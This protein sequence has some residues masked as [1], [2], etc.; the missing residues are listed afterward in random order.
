MN[1][2][3]VLFSLRDACATLNLGMRFEGIDWQIQRGQHWAVVGGNGS[4]KTALLALL[5]RRIPLSAGTLQ[6]A[7]AF[8]VERDIALVSMDEAQRLIDGDIRHDISDV[9]DNAVD[10]GTTLLQLLRQ[11]GIAEPAAREAL[12]ALGIGELAARGLRFVSTGQLRRALIARAMA[13]NYPLIAFDNPLDG[14]DAQSRDSIAASITQLMTPAQTTLYLSR[15]YSSLPAGITHVLQLRDCRV[16]YAGPRSQWQQATQQQARPAVATRAI[17]FAAPTLIHFDDVDIHYED[18]CIFRHANFS[19]HRF[20]HT[21][22][23]GPNGCGKSTLLA[24]ISGDNHKAY[25]KNISLFGRRR[26]SGESVWEIKA[27]IG[28]VSTALHSQYPRGFNGLQ[29]V[30]SGLFDTLGLYDNFGIREKNLALQ[31]LQ[32]CGLSALAD[33]AFHRASYGQQRQLLLA[34]A[35]IKQPSLLILDEPCI[36]IDEEHR[37]QFLQQLAHIMQHGECT[38][39]YVSHVAEEIPAGM[40]QQLLFVPAA[41]GGY[42][43][44]TLGLAP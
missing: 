29:V 13:G 20:Q 38:V 2:D 3:T 25:G 11:S 24:L 12:Q 33:K 8:D 4:G 27:R 1:N 43:V 16:V 42:E 32:Q 44:Q 21:L 14:L 7:A 22:V 6:V 37:A 9:C 34:R 30:L 10:A 36:G 5:Q 26:G 31:T 41:D 28:V 35:V 15:D 17:D 18:R 23:S 39:L 40:H 19:V